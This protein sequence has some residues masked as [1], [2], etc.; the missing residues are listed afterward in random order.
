MYEVRVWFRLDES[1]EVKSKSVRG[2]Y[3]K[4]AWREPCGVKAR[5][6]YRLATR[7]GKEAIEGSMTFSWLLLLAA[8]LAFAALLTF[9]TGLLLV[10]LRALLLLFSLRVVHLIEQG[11]ARRLKLISLGL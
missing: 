2:C 11:Q 10:A 1:R 5:T 4:G 9:T 3:E 8:L 6:G 7:S